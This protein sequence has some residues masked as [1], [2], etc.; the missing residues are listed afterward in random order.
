MRNPETPDDPR[1]LITQAFVPNIAVYT[2]ED[3]NE[4]AR[5]K[6]FGQGLWEIL[7]PFGE[8]VQG[9]VTIRDSIGASR[10]W[11]DFA[12]RFTQLGD[13]LSHAS[14][15]N[16]TTTADPGT[17]SV[18]TASPGS[19]VSRTGGDVD[20]IEQLLERH[21]SY[22]EGAPSV[23]EEDYLNFKDAQTMSP[24]TS[25][26]YTLYLKKLLS[27]LPLVPQETFSHPVACIIAISSRNA[28]PIETLRQLYDDTSHGAKRMP[29]WVSGEFLRY[30]VLI[31]DEEKD[32]VTK[33][34]H[35]FEQMKRHF[36]LH[37]HLLRLR[38]SQCVPTDD[39]STP[40]PRCHW[41]TAS[42]ELSEIE[43]NENQEDMA[44]QSPCIFESDTTAIKSF[45]REMVT[46]SVVPS[47]E[48]C[49][50]TWN[51]QVASRRKGLSGRLL[52]LSKRWT[53]F[54][55]GSRNSS[56]SSGNGSSTNYDAAQ[57]IYQPDSAEAT[58]RKLA[59]YAFML[60]DWKLALSTYEL[61]RSD[62]NTDKAWRYHAAANEM[63]AISTLLV[64]Q[65]MSSK[66]RAETVDQMLGTATYS[67]ITRCRDSYGALRCLTLGMELLR[68]RGGSATDDA[69]RWGTKLLE[70]NVVREVGAA[71][72]KERLAACYASRKGTGSQGWGLRTRRSAFWSIL[73]ADSWLN[74]SKCVQADRQLREA[75][76]LYA[77]LPSGGS[78]SRFSAADAFV[79][80]LHRDLEMA[81]SATNLAN[82]QGARAT[83]LDIPMDEE[84]EAL[85]AGNR[86]K[87]LIGAN[88]P[89]A[90]VLA[91]A[92]LRTMSDNSTVGKPDDFE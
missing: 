46:Q 8:H 67:Y 65:V 92:P 83:T 70:L 17:N 9:K 41:T 82:D 11:D 12:V 89:Q 63:A 37:C 87:S 88:A 79:K 69:A 10:I 57:G 5:D 86:R 53:G 38:S 7:R 36:G 29:L 73:A 6:G 3:M 61:L 43:I 2:S 19:R 21:L 20:H 35:L 55:S 48:R 52:G 1:N 28:N 15:P 44:D 91:A 49:I 51:E 42:E 45:I 30:Y 72:I 60:R 54:G 59:D 84:S 25:P 31:H 32:D 75:E 64:P 33:S 4:L 85:D 16:H 68:L 23:I 14:P 47:M 80:N 24:S 62:F 56:G 78:L 39:D 71:L 22:A 77:T 40:L 90:M 34:L 66:S 58:M 74:M 76:R 27:G 26:F 81:T 50:A 13:G 18:A